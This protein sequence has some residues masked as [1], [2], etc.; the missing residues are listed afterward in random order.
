MWEQSK[1][2]KRRFNDGLFHSRYFVGHGIDI[3]GEPD[4]LAQYVGVFPLMQQVD[5]WDVENGDAQVMDGVPDG[6]FD[7]V[8]SSHCLEHMV[9]VKTAL[10]N[11]TRIVRPGGYLIVTVPDEDLYERGEWPSTYNADHKWSFTVCKRASHM[12][13]SINVVDLVT[14][15]S[16]SLELERL[17]LVRDFFRSSLPREVDQSMTPVAECCIEIIWRKR[18]PGLEDKRT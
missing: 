7:F 10:R 14:E 15:F 6:R 18:P 5:T 12:P 3:G 1:A 13:K 16:E 11:W 2:A 17:L 9:D 4:P 8:H